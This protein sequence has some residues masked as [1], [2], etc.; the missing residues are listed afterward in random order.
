MH[1]G[2]VHDTAFFFSCFPLETLQNSAR[3][4]DLVRLLRISCNFREPNPFSGDGNIRQRSR[5]SCFR[6]GCTVSRVWMAQAMCKYK[7]Q[8]SNTSPK[9][10]ESRIWFS[11]RGDW[12][13]GLSRELQRCGGRAAMDLSCACWLSSTSIVSLKFTP[14]S[15]SKSHSKL[16]FDS[17][18]IQLTNFTTD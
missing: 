5:L 10:I 16:I 6:R 2:Q 8:L 15:I 3:F 12:A 9:K 1:K 13:E 7:F 17:L 14:I 11:I 4:Y 18:F